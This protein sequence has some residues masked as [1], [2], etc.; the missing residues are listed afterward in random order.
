VKDPMIGDPVEVIWEVWCVV[1]RG[2]LNVAFGASGGHIFIQKKRLGPHEL[3]TGVIA[4][5][6]AHDPLFTARF[7]GANACK[8]RQ[9]FLQWRFE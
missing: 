3:G 6:K 5:T 2:A 8:V 4:F 1:S 7:C 9:K